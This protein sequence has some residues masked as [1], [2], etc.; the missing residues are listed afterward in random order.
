[1]WLLVY[2]AWRGPWANI[3][4]MVL[5]M[6]DIPK[7]TSEI[8]TCLLILKTLKHEYNVKRNTK[9]L[10][11]LP[12]PAGCSDVMWRRDSVWYLFT[13]IRKLCKLCLWP[14]WPWP[15]TYDLDHRT[16]SRYHQG[17]SL[18]MTIPHDHTSNGSAMRALTDRQTHTHTHTDGSVSIPST[19][20]GGGKKS[21]DLIFVS[22]C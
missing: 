9:V 16:R 6:Q 8:M 17:Q 18:Y 2:P 5:F 22:F 4:C 15:L 13:E 3:F 1:M 14:W 20:D 12:R 19:A 7:F 11:H 21:R 10:L